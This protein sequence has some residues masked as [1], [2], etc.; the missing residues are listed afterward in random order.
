MFRCC[1]ADIYFIAG[2]FY[3]HHYNFNHMIQHK[4]L[5]HIAVPINCY[6]CATTCAGSLFYSLFF[7]LLCFRVAGL[8][9]IHC[10]QMRTYTR[11]QNCFRPAVC[12]VYRSYTA[13][14]WPAETHKPCANSTF[15]SYSSHT[16][17]KIKK[18]KQS[19][20]QCRTIISLMLK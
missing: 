12:K 14:I 8:F 9:H 15:F 6:E 3:K 13:A 1:G 11:S 18:Q 5:L 20:V 2:A 19:T 4:C 17:N 16:W 7:S 10:L